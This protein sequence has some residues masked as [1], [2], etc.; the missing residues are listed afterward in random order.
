MTFS[1]YLNT[2]GLKQYLLY[3]ARVKIVPKVDVKL[4]PK[5]T[6]ALLKPQK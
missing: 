2:H 6:C 3:C 5:T 4:T 1:E